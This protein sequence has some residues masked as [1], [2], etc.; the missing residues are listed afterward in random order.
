MSDAK[1]CPTCGGQ[2]WITLKQHDQ[3]IAKV[4]RIDAEIVRLA[5]EKTKWIYKYCAMRTRAEKNGTERRGG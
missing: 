4:A 3:L 1:V 5:I 2:G